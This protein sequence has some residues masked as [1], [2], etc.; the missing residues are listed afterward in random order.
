MPAGSLFLP[1]VNMYGTVQVFTQIQ[2]LQYNGCDSILTVNLTI[3]EINTLVLEDGNMFWAQQADAVYQWLQCNDNYSPIPNASDSV[4]A[5]SQRG[6]YAVEI[7][8]NN[9]K[10]TSEC[11]ATNLRD[12]ISN[13][14]G[15]HLIISP[16]PTTGSVTITLPDAYEKTDVEL[17]DQTGKTLWKKSYTRK[18][19]ISLWLERTSWSLFSY[20]QE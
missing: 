14:L 10:D 15:A 11:Y 8:V 4:Y 6:Y 5:P 20:D 1:V 12:F 7:T 2:Y 19:E 3:P 18:K 17:A 16:N 13:T 9:C